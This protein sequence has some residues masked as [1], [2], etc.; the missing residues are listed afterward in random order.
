[1]NRI[2]NVAPD[3]EKVILSFPRYEGAGTPGFVTDFLGVRTRLSYFSG[4]DHY[5]GMVETY[6]LPCN[7]HANA[8]EWAGVLRAVEEAEGPGFVALELGAGWG[9]WLVTAGVAARNKGLANVR[10]IGVEGSGKHLDFMRTHFRDNRFDPG[11][12]QLLHGIV[13]P[14]DGTA[15]FP[16]IPEG[17]ADWGAEAKFQTRLAVTPIAPPQRGLVRRLGRPV[18][19][20]LRKIKAVH[21]LQNPPLNPAVRTE[22]LPCYSLRTLLEPYPAADFV[23]IDIQG[24][25][26]DVIA[27][28]RAVLE[29]KVRR[30]IIGTHGR[31]IEERL[32]REL[33]GRG[34]RLESEEACVFEQNDEHIYLRGDGCQVWKNPRLG[35]QQR[36]AA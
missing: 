32:M 5:G 35:R 18:I 3:D 27:A 15:H 26:F 13:G 22:Q 1:M 31:L 33:A 9:P 28:A 7:F 14:H 36:R 8:I 6:P 4:I 11:E 17:A 25:E 30:L 12:H 2:P 10:L 23:H 34:W 29:A 19:R 24:A 21:R 16:I 20:L